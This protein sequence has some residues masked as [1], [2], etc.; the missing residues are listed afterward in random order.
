MRVLTHPT[1]QHSPR[2]KWPPNVRRKSCLARDAF[3]TRDDSLVPRVDICQR[4]LTG[5]SARQ[6][7]CSQMTSFLPRVSRLPPAIA[8]FTA[9]TPRL[10]PMRAGRPNPRQHHA[11]L[12]P[13]SAPKSA[14]TSS[15]AVATDISVKR[16]FSTL[17]RHSGSLAMYWRICAASGS[18]LSVCRC[19]MA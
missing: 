7:A 3:T 14:C 8:D 1:M 10:T 16:S 4:A 6:A 2:R 19:S 11:L 15:I 12:S 5:Y 17:G 13:P 9:P 18:M